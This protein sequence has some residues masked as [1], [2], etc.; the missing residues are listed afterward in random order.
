MT[1]LEKYVP[2]FVDEKLTRAFEKDLEKI[3]EG[4]VKKETVL[5]KAKKSLS[6]RIKT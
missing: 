6:Q 5:N 4:K 1:A 2:D 3:M